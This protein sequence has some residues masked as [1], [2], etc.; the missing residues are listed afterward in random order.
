METYELILMIAVGLA[1]MFF[2]YRIKK[3]AFFIIWFLIGYNIM[4]SLMPIINTAV[5]QIAANQ[6][7]QNL[8]P[9]AGGLLLALLGFSVEKLCVG[10]ICFGIIMVITVK[11]F[12]TDM[13]VLAVGAIIGVVAAGAA[14][15]Y[16]GNCCCWFLCRHDCIFG[17]NKAKLS[18]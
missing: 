18:F 13:G 17:A 14:C 16:C 10:G 12:G 6:L 11:Y 8:L 7:Y 2:G 5:P 9:I 4:I 1:L 15:R 3:V